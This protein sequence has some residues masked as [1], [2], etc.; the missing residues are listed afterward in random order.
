[1]GLSEDSRCYVQSRSQLARGTIAN[2]L[3]K[4][5]IEPAPHRI[6]KTTSKEFLGRHWELIVAADFFTVEVWARRGLQRYIV[7]ELS[8]RRV[9]VARDC[10]R[11]QW[12]LDEPN[13]TEHQRQRRRP[14][15]RKTLHYS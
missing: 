14:P 13:R 1:M 8:M 7:L 10:S 9:E 11:G 2:I 12:S 15:D 5:G 6:R 4:H 3:E